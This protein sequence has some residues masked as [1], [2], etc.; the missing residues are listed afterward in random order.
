MSGIFAMYLIFAAR[1]AFPSRFGPVT[2]R[3]PA[4]TL[5]NT[6]GAAIDLFSGQAG[7]GGGILANIF[8]GLSGMPMHKSIGRAAAAASVRHFWAHKRT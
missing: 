1:F 3:P 4:N 5:R 6:G 8:M 2:E 7:V